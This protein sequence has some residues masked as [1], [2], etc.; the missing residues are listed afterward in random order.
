MLRPAPPLI[1]LSGSHQ[2]SEPAWSY[3]GGIGDAITLAS[4][5]QQELSSV[6]VSLAVPSA[7]DVI[8][9]KEQESGRRRRSWP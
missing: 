4:Q 7:R 9:G 2:L 1:L 6:D 3:G 8:K 5:V